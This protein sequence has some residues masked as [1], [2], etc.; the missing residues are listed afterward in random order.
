MTLVRLN[1]RNFV[2]T[3][4]TNYGMDDMFNWFMNES[5]SFGECSNHPSA[6]I[7]ETEN[8]FRIE[9]MV[10]GYKKENIRIQFENGVLTVKHVGEENDNQNVGSYLSREFSSRDFERKFKLSDRLASDKISASYENG[11]LEIAIPIKE[12]AKAKPVQ[13][14]SID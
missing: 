3:R 11:V 2:P 4:R 1:N 5:P 7:R 10:P 6:N 12:E 13:E 8:D 9:L 14:I